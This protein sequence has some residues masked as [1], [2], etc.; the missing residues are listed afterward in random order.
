MAQRVSALGAWA[1]MREEG[2][3]IHGVHLCGFAAGT[4]EELVAL[5]FDKGQLCIVP[6]L[7]LGPSRPPR[8]GDYPARA[9]RVIVVATAAVA[10]S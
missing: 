7:A 8:L 6:G 2:R 3:R 9:R 5:I 10:A 4:A 1:A